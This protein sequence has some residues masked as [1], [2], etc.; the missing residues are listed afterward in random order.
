MVSRGYL[1][2]PW[3]YNG[4]PI[5]LPNLSDDPLRLV[6]CSSAYR[7]G[8]PAGIHDY[9]FTLSVVAVLYLLFSRHRARRSHDFLHRCSEILS[10]GGRKSRDQTGM[11]NFVGVLDF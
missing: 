9:Q 4:L 8:P 7:H 10:Y 11:P 6:P 5:P 1:H 3:G 2:G